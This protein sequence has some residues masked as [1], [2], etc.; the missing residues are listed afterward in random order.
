LS[1]IL[2]T[3]LEKTVF[4]LDRENPKRGVL[5]QVIIFIAVGV[6]TIER[7]HDGLFT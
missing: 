3:G 6:L 4:F 2:R 7:S 5:S 1:V